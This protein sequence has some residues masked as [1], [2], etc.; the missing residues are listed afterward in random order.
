M[1]VDEYQ[2][3]LDEFTINP[4]FGEVAMGCIVY[5]PDEGV[6]IGDYPFPSEWMN[7]ETDLTENVFGYSNFLK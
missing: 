5:D 1:K 4:R 3:V 7:I 2:T 6:I